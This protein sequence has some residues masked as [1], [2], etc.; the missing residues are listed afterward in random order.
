MVNLRECVCTDKCQ[1]E[2]YKADTVCHL[3]LFGRL[4][5]EPT[6]NIPATAE[7]REARRLAAW[8]RWY[9]TLPADLRRK[10]SLHDFKRLSDCFKQAFGINQILPPPEG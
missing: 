8:D 3:R 4:R 10:L 5:E 7:E 1:R 6:I 9:A 2:Q